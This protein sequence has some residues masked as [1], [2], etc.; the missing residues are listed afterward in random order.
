MPRATI[1][2]PPR[3]CAFAVSAFSAFIARYAPDAYVACRV[4]CLAA[5]YC[6]S[7]PAFAARHAVLRFFV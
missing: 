2:S 7:P 6:V 3:G 5:R 1:V 4:A